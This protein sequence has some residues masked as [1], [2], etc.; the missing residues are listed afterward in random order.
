MM[1][2]MVPVD[3]ANGNLIQVSIVADN[4]KTIEDELEETVVNTEHTYTLQFQFLRTFNIL[5]EDDT[6]PTNAYIQVTGE[7]DPRFADEN[8]VVAFRTS[9]A[10][11][12]IASS[13]DEDIYCKPLITYYNYTPIILFY[14]PYIFADPIVQAIVVANWDT[15][16][17][18][19]ITRPEINQITD[20]NLKFKGNTG[21][22]SFNELQ[23]F[24]GLTRF[25]DS[26][27]LAHL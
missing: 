4:C 23:D 10:I 3:I 6:V 16:G 12:G 7:V 11:S 8:G 9:D 22:T 24:N 25:Q 20:L 26:E 19:I 18:G 17:D 27:F 2:L 15:D 21:I 5:L 1:Q 14:I 13:E